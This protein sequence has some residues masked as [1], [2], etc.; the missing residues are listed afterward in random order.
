MPENVL[1]ALRK[2]TG[3]QSDKVGQK[4]IL[5]GSFLSFFESSRSFSRR[6]SRTAGCNGVCEQPSYGVS[7][8]NRPIDSTRSR[9]TNWY[10]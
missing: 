3:D 5:Q 8:F 4:I 7:K 6:V 2:M 1:D 9:S 10:I